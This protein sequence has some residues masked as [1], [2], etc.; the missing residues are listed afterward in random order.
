[1]RNKIVLSVFF[2]VLAFTSL[3]V[4]AVPLVNEK[5]QVEL[6]ASGMG[7]V[8]GLTI[9]IDGNLYAADY[10][11]GRILRITGNNSYDVY[12]SGLSYVT[13]LTFT[14]NGRLFATSSTNENSSILEIAPNG[15]ASIFSSGYS[16]P[17]SLEALGNT[18]FVTNS[19]DG[20][21]S[22]V[23]ESGIASTFL[24]GFSTPHGPFGISF[25]DDGTMYFVDHGTGIVYSADQAGNTQI[26]G[27]VS[28]LGGTYTGFGF[29][30]NLLVS[31][32]NAGS[33]YNLDS[34][35]LS[36]FASG[37]EGKSNPPVIGPN[38]FIFDGVNS[39]YV[40]DGDYIW[41][42]A[43]SVPEPTSLTLLGLGLIGFAFS[44][45]KKL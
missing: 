33:I 1:M 5:Y 8:T 10:Q 16:F 24:S 17:T 30:N 12:S 32:V 19:G 43:R 4:F 36:I 42:I 15:S 28:R 14:D 2:V 7:A 41:R 13:D 35:G 31:D 22:R 39:L 34:S 27:S 20:T 26:W 44:R 9:G 6:Y 21:I 25:N 37:F 38:D 3:H 11:G 18:L 45:R 40:G 29:D 23:N